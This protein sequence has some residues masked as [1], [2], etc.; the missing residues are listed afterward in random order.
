MLE[1]ETVLAEAEE[2]MDTAATA[3]TTVEVKNLPERFMNLPPSIY[4][5]CTSFLL[6]SSAILNQKN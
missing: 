5:I 3:A 1:T 6:A 2:T 4:V